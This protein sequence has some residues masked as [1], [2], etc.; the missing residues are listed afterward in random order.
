MTSLSS[1][2]NNKKENIFH[3]RH[4]SLSNISWK[5]IGAYHRYCNTITIAL[6]LLRIFTED[7][8]NVT[9]NDPLF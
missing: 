6:F 9:E 4:G 1:K 3:S 5:S 2:N 8:S 7:Q